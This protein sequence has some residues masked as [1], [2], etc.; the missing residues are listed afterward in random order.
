MIAIREQQIKVF[1]ELT[2]FEQRIVCQQLPNSFYE[3][4]IDTHAEQNM[5]KSRKII[6][7]FKRRMLN[8]KLEEF[9][10]KVQHYEHLYQEELNTFQLEMMNDINSQQLDQLEMLKHSVQTYLYHHTTKF[11]R[12]IRWKESNYHVKL[13]QCY[14]RQLSSTRKINITDVYPQ[15]IVDVE[16]ISLNRIQLDYLS[17]NGKL[18]ILFDEEI[19]IM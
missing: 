1:E 5:N 19:F 8:D 10:M 12:Q 16:K 3:A 15:I 7:E 18:N 14:Y 2:M 4:N 6:Q 13:V 9:E 11:I 17:H